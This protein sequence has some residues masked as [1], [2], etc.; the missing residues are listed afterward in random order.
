MCVA[1]LA[2]RD[3]LCNEAQE[4]HHGEAACAT[5]ETCVRKKSLKES[6]NGQA[7]CAAAVAVVLCVSLESKV[8]A[9]LKLPAR[10]KHKHALF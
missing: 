1:H 10:G 5:A 8:K 3:V 7:A 4:R 9:L 6:H 2:S